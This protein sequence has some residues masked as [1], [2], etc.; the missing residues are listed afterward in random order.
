AVHTASGDDLAFGSD[1]LLAGADDDVD[2]F[3][4]NLA[5]AG[6]GNA[7][8]PG[9]L[10]EMVLAGATSLKLN[11]DWGTTPGAIDCCLSVAD[12]YDVQ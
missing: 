2:A 1:R 6:K 9:A 5:F 11:E 4:M 3:P 8:L 7:S 10:T 12:E